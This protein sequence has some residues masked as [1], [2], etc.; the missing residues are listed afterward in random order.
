MD[1][2]EKNRR[3]GRNQKSVTSGNESH[4]LFVP[5][6]KENILPCRWLIPPLFYAQFTAI[7]IPLFLYFFISLF[8]S[9]ISPCG[10]YHKIF[11]GIFL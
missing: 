8:L 1:C 7:S 4:G 3:E 6:C 9:F 5:V 10:V 11:S 2:E